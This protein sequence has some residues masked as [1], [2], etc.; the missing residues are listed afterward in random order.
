MPAISVIMPAYNC[1]AF[2]RESVESIL[3]QTFTDFEFFI[4][5][6]AST[7]RTVEIIK[8]Y[9]D[10]RINLIVKPANTG[11][12]DSLN[13]AIKFAKGKYIARMDADDISLPDRLSR[14]Y[15]YLRQHDDVGI[16]G[17]NI[18][19]FGSKSGLSKYLENHS[20]IIKNL[21]FSCPFA[22]PTVMMQKKIFTE[23]ALYYDK[24]F[25]PAEDYDLWIKILSV[26]K[27]HN[28]QIPL[29]K[30]RAHEKQISVSANSLQKSSTIKIQTM[31]LVQQF[32]SELSYAVKTLVKINNGIFDQLPFSV[33]NAYERLYE[34]AIQRNND[35]LANK[36]IESFLLYIKLFPYHKIEYLT[37]FK[38]SFLFAKIS[39][40]ARLIFTAKAFKSDFF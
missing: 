6:D 39:L 36:V 40:R 4:I 37:M 15:D 11:Y 8:E 22:H 33:R 31:I 23:H 9:N 18:T 29:L 24:N 13:M 30:Y 26:T 10:T 2:I 32:G 27:G 34:N 5:D 14:Q 16:C 3:S 7:D 20:D 1:E 38:K 28:I 35:D 25:E 12:T 21:G 17:T 19:F